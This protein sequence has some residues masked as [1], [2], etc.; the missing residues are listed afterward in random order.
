MA[1]RLKTRT[2]QL[3]LT[4]R[5]NLR[6]SYCYEVRAERSSRAMSV[7]TA[8]EIAAR[9]MHEEG[10]H[11]T[12]DFDFIGGEPLL[13]WDVIVSLVEY[14]HSQRWP[15][16][17][18][19]SFTTN[20]TLFTDEIKAWL[21][22]HSCVAFGFSIDGTRTAHNLNRCDSYDRMIRHV[23]WALERCTRMG[24]EK[25]A[26]MTIGPDTI[27]MI[28]DG[29]AEIHAMGFDQIGANVP[30]ENIWGDRLDSSMAQF[31]DQLE[32]LIQFYLQHPHLEPSRLIDL[33][34]EKIFAKGDDAEFPRWC[35]SGG[36]MICYDVDG[37]PLPCHRFVPVS[38]GRT[39]AGPLVFTP[40]TWDE[41]RKAEP[42]PCVAC[43]F[44]SG[45][46]SCMALNWLENGDIDRRTNWHCGFILLQ[47]KASAKFKIA[48]LSRE[49][50]SAPQ[51]EEG[52]VKV[53]E[54]QYQLDHALQVHEL[55]S[56]PA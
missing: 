55:L 29:I 23:P 30:F 7:A 53:S 48:K 39:Y 56:S 33:P 32:A 24:F 35:G 25:R 49:I 36:P 16:K 14:V 47:M 4:D 43:P 44:V 1:E 40:K 6:C 38:T 45:C 19:F 15:K 54:L 21:D 18:V 2:V 20:G 41:V 10:P 3:H 9:H 17:F 50:V 52:R 5:C 22:R 11:E 46:P 34:F 31:S 28:A 51:T 12:V 27:S 8:K 13:V 42:S 37:N 26:K